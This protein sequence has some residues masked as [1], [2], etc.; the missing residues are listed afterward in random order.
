MRAMKQKTE[1]FKTLLK[2]IENYSGCKAGKLHPLFDIQKGVNR[3]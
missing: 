1:L 3:P 2:N